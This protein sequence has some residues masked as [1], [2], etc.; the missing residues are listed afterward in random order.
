MGDRVPT[1]WEERLSSLRPRR[2]GG[3]CGERSGMLGPHL[4]PPKGLKLLSCWLGLASPAFGVGA[5][6][7]R[8]GLSQG[9]KGVAEIRGFLRKNSP[10]PQMLIT[11]VGTLNGAA[12][13]ASGAGKGMA[14]LAESGVKG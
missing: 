10:D 1:P 3:E 12:E 11:P 2:Q 4:R 7:E 14:R 9:R 13:G 8:A 6:S 5:Q